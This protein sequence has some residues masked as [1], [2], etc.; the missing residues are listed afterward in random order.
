MKPDPNTE[1]ENLRAITKKQASQLEDL[2]AQLKICM[3]SNKELL[4]ANAQLSAA[5]LAEKGKKKP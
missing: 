4:E 2:A 5:L 3:R 1:L